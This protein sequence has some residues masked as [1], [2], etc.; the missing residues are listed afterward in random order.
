MAEEISREIKEPIEK[1]LSEEARKIYEE[2]T[3]KRWEEK[4][5][6]EEEA[7]EYVRKAA[8]RL[9]EKWQK[10]G[11]EYYTAVKQILGA[12]PPREEVLVYRV[13]KV[14]EVKG[15]KLVPTDKT[16]FKILPL[17]PSKPPE[18]PPRAI[19]KCPICGTY[20][21]KQISAGLWQCTNDPTHFVSILEWFPRRR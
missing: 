14:G 21:M 11:K 20:T 10:I 2:E 17:E 9:L 16:T 5:P 19:L 1:L 8:R 12:P 6:T 3:G 4:P 7:K 18:I 15:G 13:D